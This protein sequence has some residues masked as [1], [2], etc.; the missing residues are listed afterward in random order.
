MVNRIKK[1][2][3][4]QMVSENLNQLVHKKSAVNEMHLNNYNP[5]TR[6]KSSIKIIKEVLSQCIFIAFSLK[7]LSQMMI[8]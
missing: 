5:S 8:S 1:Q 2:T 6:K 4:G 3:N 7:I